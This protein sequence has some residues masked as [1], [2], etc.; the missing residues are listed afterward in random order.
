LRKVN[1][2]LCNG[3][4]VGDWSGPSVISIAGIAIVRTMDTSYLV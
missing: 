1:F 4:G 2:D 3:G